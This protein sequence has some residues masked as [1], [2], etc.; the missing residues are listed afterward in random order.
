VAAP[1]EI[2]YALCSGRQGGVQYKLLRE[3]LDRL[4]NVSLDLTLV[5]VDDGDEKWIASKRRRI[6]P[7]L[8]VHERVNGDVMRATSTVGLRL[9]PWLV[10]Q[11][12][13]D[14]VAAIRWQVLRGLSG[15]AKRLA[16]WLSAC[17]A[18]FQPI[19]DHTEPFTVQ[20]TDEL[21]GEFGITAARERDR[22]ASIARAASKIAETDPRYSRMVLERIGGVYVLRVDRPRKGNVLQLPGPRRA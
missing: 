4:Y 13:A 3:S 8:T 17:G 18:D 10:G 2:A 6:V 14:T 22:R 16:V 21:D 7:E 1:G 19:T 9:G 5:T 11:L 12:D 15:I 20:L